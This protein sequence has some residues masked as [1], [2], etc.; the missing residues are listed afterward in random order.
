M[1]NATNILGTL[2]M[3]AALAGAATS[4]KNIVSPTVALASC[5]EWPGRIGRYY[6]SF[7]NEVCTGQCCNP[8]AFGC[9]GDPPPLECP[10]EGC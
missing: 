8:S 4:A 5:E 9:C 3:L 2:M 6:D 7:G 1:A 10:P